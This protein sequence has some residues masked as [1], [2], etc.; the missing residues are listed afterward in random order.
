ME[1]TPLTVSPS[2][3]LTP[4]T[5]PLGTVR[6]FDRVDWLSFGLATTVAFLCYW[7]TL[8]PNLTL[9]MSGLMSTGAM[10]AGVPH[11][12]GYPA[13]TLYA[14]A[15]TKLIPFSNIAWRVALSSAVASAVA[16]GLI[17]LI[18]SRCG[19]MIFRRDDCHSKILSEAEAKVRSIC[20]VAAA[21]VLAFSNVVWRNAVIAY[22]AGLS[23]LLFMSAV[24]FL[25]AWMIQSRK[26]FLALAFL[27]FGLLLTSNQELIVMFPG[28]LLATMIARPSVGRDLTF[29]FV[30]LVGLAT[31]FNQYALWKEPF[32]E[33]NNWFRLAF[34]GLLLA[35]GTLVVKTRRVG[36]EWRTVL[37]CAAA[38]LFGYAFYL[39]VPLAA[40][41]T[42]PVN[43][44]YARTAEGF[45]HVIARGQFERITVLECDPF[46]VKEK[47]SRWFVALGNDYG[48]LYVVVASAQFCLWQRPDKE[49][50]Q[51]M[52]ALM[53]LGLG[54]G[55]LLLVHLNPLT[56]N[57]PYATR[58]HFAAMYAV[59]SITL[60][61]G[62]IVFS[63]WIVETKWFN[64]A[65]SL[66]APE[67]TP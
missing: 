37:A 17:A 42:P 65:N 29:V 4:P 23:L 6:C 49:L 52:W 41:T 43:W 44:G 11:V 7:F 32:V 39:Y 47:L 53:A 64:A 59:T 28:I 12:P 58:T 21:L 33:P 18:V 24:A 40:M 63:R 13:W 57:V 3:N 20:G 1:S 62:L 36:T 8:P 60:G 15:F 67:P 34:F 31:A 54:V 51:W 22:P 38:F 55:P 5:K 2:D 25:F 30:P 50:R 10:Y 16:C 35:T 56:D 14:W 48:W 45:F 46:L 61:I 66:A 9:D 26:V 19:V 27:C